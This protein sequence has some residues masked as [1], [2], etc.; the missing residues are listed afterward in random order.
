MRE[1]SLFWSLI[2]P[3]GILSVSTVLTFWL[4]RHFSKSGKD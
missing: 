2:V 3:A 4:Y 1:F